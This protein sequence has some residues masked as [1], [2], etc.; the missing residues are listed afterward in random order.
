MYSRI[1]L[2]P[3]LCAVLAAVT[4][5]SCLS[6]MAMIG[7]M[8]PKSFGPTLGTGVA[9]HDASTDDD[10]NFMGDLDESDSTVTIGANAKFSENVAADIQYVDLGKIKFNGVFGGGTSVGTVESKGIEL[11]A[12]GKLP[13]GNG[14][15]ETGKVGGLFWDGEEKERFGG[16]PLNKSDSGLDPL[17]GVGIEKSI[18]DNITADVTW[19]RYFGV[20]DNNV[21]ALVF[22]LRFGQ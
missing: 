22:R 8:T 16:A 9:V 15:K 20:F 2:R 12:T 1:G 18:T 13:I 11:S 21:D 6:I 10:A 4:L 14:F 5:S 3:V 19:T 17:I 7:A